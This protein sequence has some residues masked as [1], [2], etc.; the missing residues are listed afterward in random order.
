M[1]VDGDNASRAAHR[2]RAAG[3]RRWVRPAVLLVVAV[4]LAVEATLV[5]RLGALRR[6]VPHRAPDRGGRGG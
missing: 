3:S 2:P 1:S 6:P 4:V 5:P